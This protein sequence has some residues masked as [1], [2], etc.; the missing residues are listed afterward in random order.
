MVIRLKDQALTQISE[1]SKAMTDV[2]TIFDIFYMKS[3]DAWAKLGKLQIDTIDEPAGNWLVL[4]RSYRQ[5]KIV[6]ERV[7][8]S[9]KPPILIAFYEAKDMM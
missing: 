1:G 5:Y 7:A 4:P 6:V 8:L 3:Y 9:Y 2:H